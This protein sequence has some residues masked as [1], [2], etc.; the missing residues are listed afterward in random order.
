MSGVRS[1]PTVD[2]PGKCLPGRLVEEM[3]EVGDSGSP[4]R[5]GGIP[6]GKTQSL[7]L[8][9]AFLPMA[10]QAGVPSLR[11]SGSSFDS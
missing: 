7:F 10:L 5:G 3:S 11:T 2:S 9:I 1:R 6:G 8:S 4:Q